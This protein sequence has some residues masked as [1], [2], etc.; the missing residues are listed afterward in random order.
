MKIIFAD[1]CLEYGQSGHPETP[2]RVR[3]VYEALKDEYE[4]IAPEPA[5]E[6]DV[7]LVH[8]K[9]LLDRVKSGSFYDG[10]SPVYPNLYS[11][12]MLAVG[13]ALAAAEYAINGIPSF[14]IMRPPGHH[15]G[16]GF[17]GGFCYFNN[18]AIAA[19]RALDKVNKVAI[20]D[21]DC[22]HGNGTQDIFM[23]HERVLYVSLHQSPLYPGTGTRTELNCLNYPV[24]AGTDEAAYLDTF[25]EALGEVNYFNP[26]LVAVSA[27]FDTFRED[28]ITHLNL[29]IGTF[30]KIGRLIEALDKPVFSVLEGG[31]S[32]K[33]PQCAQ[34]YLKGLKP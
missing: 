3:S 27:G 4:I 21:F 8:S 17:L 32:A 2:E 23:E 22:H 5:T 14:S 30:E 28:P 6:D 34:S 1:S 10:D 33:M 13:G 19:A 26:D 31:Y 12:V 15:A 16:T 29:D 20:I 7:L 9:E 24:L 25:S 11:H 18:I